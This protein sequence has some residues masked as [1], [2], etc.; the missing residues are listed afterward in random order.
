MTETDVAVNR[1]LLKRAC[2]LLQQYR[3]TL[4]NSDYPPDTYRAD[5]CTDVLEQI[6][7]RLK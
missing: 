3:F 7:S 4:E 1:D 6:W 5:S 2:T